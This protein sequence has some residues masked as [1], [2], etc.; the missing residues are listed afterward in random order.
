MAAATRTRRDPRTP[1]TSAMDGER[2]AFSPTEF[3]AVLADHVL[4]SN[5]PGTWFGCRVITTDRRVGVTN[6]AL[7]TLDTL[8]GALHSA[9][10]VALS[11]RQRD[12]L[13]RSY[14][15]AHLQLLSDVGPNLFPH[16]SPEARVIAWLA[17]Q[18]ERAGWLDEALTGTLLAKESSYPD[19]MWIHE[20]HRGLVARRCAREET[21]TIL[22][23]FPLRTFHLLPDAREALGTA[24]D[25]AIAELRAGRHQLDKDQLLRCRQAW[26]HAISLRRINN[27]V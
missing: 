26:R 1:N 6:L 22:R 23:Y 19:R 5:A 13:F 16:Q 14:E 24:S 9:G 21:K 3:A 4:P 18:S 11:L 27:A 25:G 10:A 2:V 12:G 17:S 20:V 8:V 15:V 7:L